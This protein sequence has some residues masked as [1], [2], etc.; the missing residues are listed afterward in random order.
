MGIHWKVTL[1]VK[2]GRP[3]KKDRPSFNKSLYILSLTVAP[4]FQKINIGIPGVY[5]IVFPCYINISGI[6]GC[7]TGC[8]IIH[9]G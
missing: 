1:N 6:I 2:K 7:N 9:W 5:V 4:N 8:I 3:C